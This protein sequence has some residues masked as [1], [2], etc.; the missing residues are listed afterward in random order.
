MAKQIIGL[1]KTITT[2]SGAEVLIQEGLPLTIK[3]A[4]VTIC[5]MTKSQ[6]P[7]ETLKAYAIGAKIYTSKDYVDLSEE[8]MANLRKLINESNVF[9]ATVIGRLIEVI[10]SAKEVKDK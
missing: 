5:E 4:I 1:S 9:V 3:D 6:I 7:G 2:L 10:D 8:E